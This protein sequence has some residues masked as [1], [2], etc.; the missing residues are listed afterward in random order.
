MYIHRSSLAPLSHGK[1]INHHVKSRPNPSHRQRRRWW[2]R[3]LVVSLAAELR[4]AQASR[5]WLKWHKKFPHLWF[6][7]S[8]NNGL[9]VPLLGAYSSS[10]TITSSTGICCYFC[11]AVSVGCKCSLIMMMMMWWRSMWCSQYSVSGCGSSSI[12][13]DMWYGLAWIVSCWLQNNWMMDGGGWSE[14][15]VESVKLKMQ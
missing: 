12:V 10:F 3:C 1:H 5:P 13:D 7:M 8:N 4:E 2:I 15:K 9:L 14:I 6:K 11:S